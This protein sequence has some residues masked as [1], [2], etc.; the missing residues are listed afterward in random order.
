MRGGSRVQAKPRAKAPP[1]PRQRPPQ[2]KPRAPASA[3]R[4]SGLSPKYALLGAAAVLALALG[5]TLATGQRG[6]RLAADAAE[7]LDARMAAAGFRLR[8]VH[9]Q[10]AS[11]LATPD[12][13]K[14]AGVY[15]DQPLLGLDLEAVRQRVEAVGWVRDARIVRLLPD[16]LV[17]AVTERPQIAVWQHDGRTAVI[18]DRGQP[19]PEADPGRFPHLPLVVGAGAAE[20]ASGILPA[21]ERRPRLAARLE[22]LVRVDDRRWDLR[23]KDGSLIQLPAVGEEA[24]LMQLEQLDRR[25]HVLDL[26]FERIDLRNPHVV[27]VRPRE[28]APAGQLPAAGV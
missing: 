11:R 28:T 25:S 16:S 10:G 6:E 14:A 21:L 13:L 15:E 3:R 22:A 27:A 2:R 5:V 19:I 4:A 24:A 1:S 12:I 20:H 26:G 8:A 7:A 18:D 17:I 9:V 23:L